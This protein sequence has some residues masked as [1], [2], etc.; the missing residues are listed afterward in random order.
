LLEHG[1]ALNRAVQQYGRPVEAW[2]DLS[3]G[4]NAEA[5][6]VPAVPAGC[7]QRL[8]E[9]DDGLLAA[10]RAYYG[11]QSL[12]PVAGSQAAIQLL[13]RLRLPAR[14]GV[15]E[16]AYAEHAHACQ[17]AGHELITLDPNAPRIDDCEVVIV[18][19]PNNPT[20]H[21]WP[22]QTLLDWQRR[23][24]RRG[25]WLVVDEAFIDA[26]PEASLLPLAPLEGL[27]VLRSLGKFFGLAGLRVG[28]VCA[29]PELLSRIE[30]ALGPWGIAHPARWVATRALGDRAWQ[31][32]MRRALQARSQ[33]LS[34]LLLAYG[35]SPSGG[36][37]LFQWVETAQA[38]PWQTALARQG[39]LVRAFD[40]PPSLRFGVPA[41]EAQWQQL[42]SAL[43]SVQGELKG[44]DD[45][46]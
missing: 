26:T 18:V 5:W 20:G 4:I 43:E 42:H 6:P 32:R 44:A 34:G 45:A 46:A 12:L 24:A 33:R 40:T 36:T 3:T 28:F 1:G 14:V 16:P 35:L 2:L 10:A 13:P 7:W 21:T 38:R 8:P 22:R 19:Q 37:A 41:T 27:V 31:A 39:V 30:C 17:V 9:E 29:W 23:L 11:C 15:F 25:G